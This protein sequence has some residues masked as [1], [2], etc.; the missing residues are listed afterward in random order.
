MYPGTGMGRSDAPHAFTQLKL[1]PTPVRDKYS[2]C[3][4][5]KLKSGKHLTR[6][7][8]HPLTLRLI[9]ESAASLGGTRNKKRAPS[10]LVCTRLA[11][12]N[13]VR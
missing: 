13:I 1:C 2:I 8:G 12:K 7:L 4:K 9:L 5:L 6:P 11:S 10:P 3:V